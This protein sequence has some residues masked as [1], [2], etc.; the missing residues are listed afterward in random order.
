MADKKPIE[1]T[2]DMLQ[3][4]ES[5][6]LNFGDLDEATLAAVDA[7]LAGLETV[8]EDS[9]VEAEGTPPVDPAAP[10]PTTPPETPATPQPSEDEQALAAAREERREIEAR[11]PRS[12]AAAEPPKIDPAKVWEDDHQVNQ[13]EALAKLQKDFEE[14]KAAN[15]RGLSEREA[16]VKDMEDEAD[17]RLLQ[18]QFPEFKSTEKL[19]AME[20]RYGKFFYGV[21]AT[22]E[23]PK[24][25]QRYFSDPTFKAECEAKGFKFDKADF[26]K[27][28]SLL[29]LRAKRDALQK[30][31]PEATLADAHVI[32]LR[33]SN[34]LQAMLAQERNKGAAE[35]ADQVHAGMNRV[36]TPPIGGGQNQTNVSGFNSEAEM[37]SWLDKHPNPKTKDEK[38]TFRR[39]ESYLDAH[40]VGA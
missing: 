13:A 37:L 26:D 2:D 11:K 9:G 34:K 31:D 12:D 39:I 4:L 36:V 18:S 25:V 21:G 19:S 28:N 29:S 6:E 5:G 35:L 30:V 33:R 24:P 40:P 20:T 27:V 1:V 7:K 14:Y 38:E 23:D 8:P 17:F 22:A 10:A 3:K 15:S 16:K 32:A